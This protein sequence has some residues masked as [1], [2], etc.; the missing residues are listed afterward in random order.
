MQ[1]LPV[2]YNG[3]QYVATYLLQ[4]DPVQVVQPTFSVQFY[5]L[6]MNL[7][8]SHYLLGAYYIHWSCVNHGLNVS[9]NLVDAGM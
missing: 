7:F 6:C 3:E 8:L 9:T 4:E 1:C 5:R 2:T